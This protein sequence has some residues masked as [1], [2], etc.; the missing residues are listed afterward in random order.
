MSIPIQ[1]FEEV[2]GKPNP[3]LF[4]KAWIPDCEPRCSQCLFWGS[5]WVD[6]AY[7]ILLLNNLLKY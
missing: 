7:C 6:L 5:L 3:F 2:Q 1:E 4:V